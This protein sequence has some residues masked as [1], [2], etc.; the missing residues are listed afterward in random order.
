M[1]NAIIPNL[2]ELPA[3]RSSQIA[4][5][6]FDSNLLFV[7]F[8]RGGL[9]AY[10]DVTPAEYDALVKSDSVGSLFAKTIK[11]VKPYKR[12]DAAQKKAAAEKPVAAKPTTEVATTELKSNVVA[13]PASATPALPQEVHD[14]A[15]AAQSWTLRVAE[16]QITDVATHEAAQRMLLEIDDIRKRVVATW[17]PMKEAAFKAHRAVC[18]KENE[19][20]KPLIDADKLLKQRIGAYTFEQIKIAQQRDEQLRLAAESE[21][22]QRAVVETEET[23]IAAAEELHAMG[24]FEG[25]EDV[26]NNPMPAPIRYEMPAPVKPSVASVAGVSGNI[27]YEVSITNINDVPREYLVVDMQKT[28]AEIARRAK[29]AGGRLQV[30]GCVIRETFATRRVGRR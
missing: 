8:R 13:F 18:D 26:L 28:Q 1:T 15:N 20:L 11:G 3:E 29:Q 10:D 21:A 27:A 12:V 30:A 6:G 19:L 5:I 22:R 9:Y 23:A 25:A 7:Q 2:T 17:K 4:G 16:A 14:L 24:D